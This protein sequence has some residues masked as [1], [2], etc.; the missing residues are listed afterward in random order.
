VE[1][2]LLTSPSKEVAIIAR[3]IVQDASS[4]TGKNL[5]EISLETNLVQPTWSSPLSKFHLVLEKK[6]E[7]PEEERWRISLLQGYY[8]FLIFSELV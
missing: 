2:A 1:V 6:S 4:T 7:V 3:V 5:L 8:L